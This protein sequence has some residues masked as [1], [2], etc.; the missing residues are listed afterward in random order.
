MK[1]N[2]KCKLGVHNWT[3]GCKMARIGH[4]FKPLGEGAV[5]GDFI[6]VYVCNRCGTMR[7]SLPWFE[8]KPEME[9]ENTNKEAQ[10]C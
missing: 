4:L 1:L 7:L 10:I 2:W 6:R 9:D 3:A 8:M 5:N